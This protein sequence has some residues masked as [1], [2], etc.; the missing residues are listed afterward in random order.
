VAPADT[1][2]LALLSEVLEEDAVDVA[3]EDGAGAP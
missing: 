1:V 3:G 2:D